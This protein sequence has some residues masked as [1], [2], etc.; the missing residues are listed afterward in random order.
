MIP[1]FER[2][3]IS[4]ALD[5]MARVIGIRH[6]L[7]YEILIFSLENKRIKPLSHPLAYL[8]ITLSHPYNAIICCVVLLSEILVCVHKEIPAEWY[9]P[10]C[11]VSTILEQPELLSYKLEPLEMLHSL[12]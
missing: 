3:K 2:E 10:L 6:N 12:R 5:R 7:N 11:T 8:L 9:E 1:V 4:R